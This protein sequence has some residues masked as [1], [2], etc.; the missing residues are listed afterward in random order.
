MEKE[1][2]REIEIEWL[3]AQGPAERQTTSTRNVTAR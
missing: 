3:Q 2:E 1:K